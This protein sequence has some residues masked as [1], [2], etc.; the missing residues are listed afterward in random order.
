MTTPPSAD[1]PPIAVPDEGP[2]VSRL[3]AARRNRG[4][5][6]T[7]VA[8]RA[9]GRS[10]HHPL[11]RVSGRAHKRPGGATADGGGIRRAQGRRAAGRYSRLASGGVPAREMDRWS[12]TPAV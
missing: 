3:T 5:P 9:A 7:D 10:R 12:V 8:G 1:G 11:L 2:P 6:R 4:R